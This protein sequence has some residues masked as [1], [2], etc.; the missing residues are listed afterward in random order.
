M[1]AV[2]VAVC[3]TAGVGV[4]ADLASGAVTSAHVCFLSGHSIQEEM[5][6]GPRGGLA[7][8]VPGDPHSRP[9]C[10]DVDTDGIFLGRP[11]PLPSHFTVL[12]EPE[13]NESL[14]L[15]RL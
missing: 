12:V 5:A 4:T 14:T 11:W 3:Y 9:S 13:K 10:P 6:P 7:M 2:V 1:P 15:L 8:K